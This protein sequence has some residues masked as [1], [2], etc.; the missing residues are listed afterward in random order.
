MAFKI[1]GKVIE[2]ETGK[3]IPNLTVKAIDRDLFFDDLL[4]AVST[5]ENGNFE[6]KY[7][8]EDFQELFFDKKPDIYLKVKNPEG[9]IIHS[10]EDKVRYE[11]GETEEFIIKISK[12]LN[13]KQKEA[14]KM[15]ANIEKIR[16]VKEQHV[17]SLLKKENVVGV[18]IG[19]KIKEGEMTGE[20][21]V[22]V[23]VKEKKAKSQLNA[24]NLVEKEL[25]GVKTDIIAVG[26][27]RFQQCNQKTRKRPAYGGDS[28]GSCHSTTHGYIMAGT[29]GC[30]VIDNTDGKRC[31]LS[32]NHVLADCDSDTD[33]RANSGDPIVQPG[34]LDGGTCAT[35]ADRIATLKRW[36]PFKTTGD[37]LV[38]AAIGEI[39]NDSDVSDEI[40]CDMG[41][42]QGIRELTAD[43]IDALQVQKCGRTTCHTTGTVMDIDVTVDVEYG[44]GATYR[45]VHQIF[46][47]DMS[48][49]GDSGSLILD[50]ERKAV[51]LLFAGSDTVTVANPIQTVLDELNVEFPSP[52]EL[53]CRVGGPD[54]TIH[55]ITGGPDTPQCFIGGPNREIHCFIGPDTGWLCFW[56]G[57]N[58]PI[59][60]ACGPD[61]PLQC[62]SGGPDM[63]IN[64]RGCKTGPRMDI[65]FV[66]PIEDP[67]KLVIIDMNRI[68]NGM[69]KALKK[70]LEEMAKER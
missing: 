35:S 55:C 25:G 34:T 54:S 63:L 3:G 36:M 69:Q 29:L 40:G 8:K 42:V 59:C 22:R 50:M 51:G 61:S 27:I 9:E 21:C 12:N 65:D 48:D 56:G 11:A 68:P 13:K 33:S 49:P 17:E 28:C 32:N 57:P 16:A 44:T 62:G 47:T 20:L 67:G 64:V 14:N 53:H 15:K 19:R 26:R 39:I 4:G 2:E 43:D 7:D 31:I 5:D 66:S 38:D 24:E 6:I 58:I 18:G 60:L 41:R 45:F 52:P 30:A 37:N 23:Y 46:L 70:M 10:T 1:H